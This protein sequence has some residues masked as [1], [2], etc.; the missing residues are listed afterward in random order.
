MAYFP[1][2]ADLENLCCLVI[3]GGKIASRKIDK[4]Y[5]FGVKLKVVAPR[6]CDEIYKR[7]NIKTVQKRFEPDDLDGADFVISAT[8]DE[9]ESIRIFKLCTQKKIPVN[10]VD[11]KEKCT[12][13]FPALICEKG[14][15]VGISTGGQSPLFSKELK[16]RIKLMLDEKSLKAVNILGQYRPLIKEKIHNKKHRGEV[17]EQLLQM[18]LG[19][20]NYDEAQIKL[21]I[22][23]YSK[24]EA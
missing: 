16:K 4:L 20:P 7:H 3:G 24:N 21:L 10:T 19:D 13:L 12:F 23:E 6:I 15:T 5:P 17:Q 8:D 9:Q 22:E 11:D 1:F 2:F 18:L 14:V